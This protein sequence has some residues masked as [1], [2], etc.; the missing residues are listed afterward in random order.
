MRR[1]ITDKLP[2]QLKLRFALWTRKAVAQ[3][4]NKRFGLKLP[5]RTMGLYLKRWGLLRCAHPCGAVCGWL[6]RSAR[7]TPQKPL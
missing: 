2:E 5:V 6:S 3:L 4:L 7:L 1:L